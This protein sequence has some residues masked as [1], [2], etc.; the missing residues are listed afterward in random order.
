M[1][2][3]VW[4]VHLSPECIT[5]AH[6]LASAHAFSIAWIPS[7]HRRV[8]KLGLG[9]RQVTDAKGLQSF[10]FTLVSLSYGLLCSDIYLLP[11]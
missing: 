3:L 2:T 6:I 8:N 9:G 5:L 10:Y 11:K 4:P 7:N 1:H